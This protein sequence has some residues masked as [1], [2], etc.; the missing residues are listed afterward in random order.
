MVLIWTQWGI[1]EMVFASFDDVK[2][3][4]PIDLLGEFDTFAA[5]FYRTQR[6]LFGISATM[7]IRTLANPNRSLVFTESYTPPIAQSRFRVLDMGGCIR[8]GSSKIPDRITHEGMRH[9]WG[10]GGE[11]NSHRRRATKGRMGRTAGVDR[12]AP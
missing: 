5:S 2:E 12:H 7:R 1:G 4:A 8:M 9:Q 3:L 10:A 6:H 11:M